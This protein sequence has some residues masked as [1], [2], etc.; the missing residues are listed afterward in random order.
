MGRAVA[1]RRALRLP[2][3]WSSRRRFALALCCLLAMGVVGAWE[4]EGSASLLSSLC[5]R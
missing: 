1:V 4:P 5:P 3:A 2:E